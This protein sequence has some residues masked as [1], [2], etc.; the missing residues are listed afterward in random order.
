MSREPTRIVSCPTCKRSVPWTEDSKF[1]PFCS[2]RCQLI[3]LG[4]WAEGAHVIPGDS[5]WGDDGDGE[6]ESPDDR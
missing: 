6:G 2:H 4:A 3:D 5:Q 1:R